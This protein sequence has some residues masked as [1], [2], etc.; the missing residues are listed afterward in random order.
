[1]LRTLAAG[2]LCGVLASTAHAQAP[3]STVRICTGSKSGNYYWAAT[4]IA[5]RFSADLFTNIQVVT[6]NGSLDNLRRLATNQCDIGFSQSD[7]DGQYI[8]ENP[9]SHDMLSVLRVVYTE[10]VHILCPVASQWKSLSD[11]AN[12]KGDRRMI[13]GPDGSGTAETWRIMRQVNT[14]LYDGI[15]RVPDPS[16][17]SS[18]HTVADSHDT[19]ML[20][21]SGLNSNDMKAANALSTR[22]PN[23][24][25][26]LRLISIDDDAMTEIKGPDGAPIYKSQTV[27]AQPAHDNLPPLYDNLITTGGGI[28]SS[29]NIT[30]LTV[31]ADL[32]IRNDFKQTIGRDR[33]ARLYEAID[34]AQPTIWQRVNPAGQD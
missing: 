16:D 21:V 31:P 14:K 26:S 30:V 29:P 12:A 19:C 17:I 18:A 2:L 5:K 34:D 13:V 15:E 1:M 10:Y 6:T 23:G 3:S 8:I 7:V 11:V 22:T 24:K 9:S 25:P 28:F 33:L 32:M 4:E 20:W 27:T